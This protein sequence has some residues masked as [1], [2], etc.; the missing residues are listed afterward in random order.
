VARLIF[1]ATALKLCSEIKFAPKPNKPRRLATL[2]NFSVMSELGQSH[3]CRD[4]RVWR[5]V[6]LVCATL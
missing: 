5:R 1:H 4:V 3:R 6:Q 2:S